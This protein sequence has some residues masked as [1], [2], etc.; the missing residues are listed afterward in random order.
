MAPHIW[1]RIAKPIFGE[2]RLPVEAFRARFGCLQ[3]TPDRRTHPTF[4]LPAYLHALLDPTVDHF[5]L[6]GVLNA[7]W[8]E[9][10]DGSLL[11]DSPRM[12]AI[13]EDRVTLMT[14]RQ[15]QC[16]ARILVEIR[17][18]VDDRDALR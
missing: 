1:R 4:Y 10:A 15:K 6:L 12:R 11:Y 13:W 3:P 9:E 8:Y 5:Y 18:R 14:D 2:D 17:E 7:L 16:I